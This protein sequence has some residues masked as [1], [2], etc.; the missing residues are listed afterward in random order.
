[1]GRY[2]VHGELGRGGMGVVMRGF[3]PQLERHVAIK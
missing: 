3:D 1:V 2:Q